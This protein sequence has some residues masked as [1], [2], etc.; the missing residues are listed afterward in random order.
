[1]KSFIINVSLARK[2]A[3]IAAI[4]ALML[5]LPTLLIVR[6]NL[7]RLD[8][9]HGQ[10]A[11]IAPAK[12]AIEALNHMQQHRG[13]S[14]VV[15][16]G[17]AGS[18]GARQARQTEVVKA[19]TQLEASV[20]ALPGTALPSAVDQIAEQWRALA[21]AVDGQEV[22][23]AQSFDRHTALIARLL[24]VLEDIRQVSG[25]MLVA[26]QGVY[27]LQNGVLGHLPKVTEFFGQ[28]RGMGAGLLARG[29]ATPEQRAQIGALAAQVRRSLFNDA[30]KSLELAMRDDAAARTELGAALSAALTAADA[31]LAVVVERVVRA[32]R[33]DLPAAE[34]FAITTRAIDAQFKLIDPASRL[35][36]G[37]LQAEVEQARQE[38]LVV[39][40]GSGALALL[41]L[42]L[43][44]TVT[45]VTTQSMAA[46]LRVAEAVAAGDL[47]TEVGAAGRDETGQ[48]LRALA[49]MKDS[50][51]QVVGTVRTNADSVASA[52]AQI[53]QGNQD[54]SQRT[55][56]QASAL[57]ETAA[58]MEQLGSTVRHNADNARQANQLAQAAS[59]VA[60]EGG[61]VVA[62]VVQTMKGINDSSRRIA[63]II[64]VIDGI[65]FQTNI[66]ALNAA[67]EAARAGE[68]GRGFAVVASE[69][70][71]LAQR[72]AAAA[73]EIKTLITAS[74]EQVGQGTALVD[75]AGATMH[76]VVG[77]I[78]RV[79]DIMG[80]ISAASAEQSAGVAQVGEAVGQMDQA[81]QQ[82]AALVEESA[83]AA[84]SLK[85]Q[86][87]QL[88]QAVAVFK[89]ATGSDAQLAA[90]APVPAAAGAWDGVE[91]RGPQRATNVMRA[92]FGRQ[93]ERAK[94]A[95]AAAVVAGSQRAARTG[96]DDWTA[97]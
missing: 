85:Q 10:L 46:A 74:V 55:E 81:T 8:T 20:R 23:V 96:S 71:N 2:F 26:D 91:R 97:F 7:H 65:A 18:A 70:R 48:L 39:L 45:R 92:P 56:E 83:A 94:P 33:L 73:K 37:A 12:A 76:E 59:Q 4:A 6:D 72:S 40:G 27:F 21:V 5:A 93:A 95:P 84:A 29:E 34:Y 89:L 57:E 22:S 41:A 50:L 80:E 24:D 1:M 69:V 19:L 75:K 68:Q 11:G 35:L 16:A 52:S 13:L 66:L 82:N 38:L 88:V 78:Q 32:D 28:M 17:N 77:S 54:L 43:M 64:G 67:V 15:L 53:A 79:T 60:V 51:A 86:A 31:G 49:K 14:A 58:S 9:A 87:Q 61:Q 25:L 47:G 36:A 42:W 90:A 30:R 62:E 63:D 3:L 44:W